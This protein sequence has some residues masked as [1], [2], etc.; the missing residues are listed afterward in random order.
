MNRIE[1][2]FSRGWVRAL[3]AAL[4]VMLAAPPLLAAEAKPASSSGAEA[5][6][7]GMVNVNT[8]SLEE[9]QLLPGVGESRARSILEVRKQRGGFKSLDQLVEVKGIGDVLLDRLRPHLT[10]QGKTTARKP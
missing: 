5:A 6:L 1:T 10:L 7:T 2:R 8:A 9:L 4:A 3:L